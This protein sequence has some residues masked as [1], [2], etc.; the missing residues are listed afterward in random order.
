MNGPRFAVPD[1]ARSRLRAIVATIDREISQLPTPIITGDSQK[2]AN[3]LSAPWADLVELLALGPE[4]AV[5]ECPKCKHIGM[6]EATRCG[7]CWTRLSPPT[8]RD[9]VVG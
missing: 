6:H 9:G 1:A 7:Y 3:G 4:P 2:P 8:G 5:R